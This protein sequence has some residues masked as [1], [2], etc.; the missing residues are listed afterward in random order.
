[1]TLPAFFP[2][3]K[4]LFMTP[5]TITI[6]ASLLSFGY[7]QFMLVDAFAHVGLYLAIQNGNWKLKNSCV[8]N[9]AQNFDHFTYL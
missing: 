5:N 2:N 7:I 8:K 6:F 3:Y 9:M 1:M 4:N